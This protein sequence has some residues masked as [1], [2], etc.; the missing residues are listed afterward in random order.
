MMEIC[1][2]WNG[3]S[4]ECLLVSLWGNQRLFSWPPEG[5]QT[6]SSGLAKEDIPRREHSLFKDTGV[7][8]WEQACSGK[9]QSFLVAR[10]R[11]MSVSVLLLGGWGPEMRSDWYGGPSSWR[12]QCTRL[13]SLGFYSEADGEEFQQRSHVGRIVLIG[14]RRVK[15]WVLEVRKLP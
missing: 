4:W 15:A 6:H 14:Q 13:K 5:E 9:H 12:A 1:A 11:S 10:A 3:S 2:W 8:M 7:Y